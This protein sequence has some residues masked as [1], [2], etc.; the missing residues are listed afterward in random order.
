MK[1]KQREATFAAMLEAADRVMTADGLDTIQVHREAP[2]GTMLT[3][4]VRGRP[5]TGRTI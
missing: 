3:L 4:T 1:R 2:D 5:Q